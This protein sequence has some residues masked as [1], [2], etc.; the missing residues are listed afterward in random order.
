MGCH[1]FEKGRRRRPLPSDLGRYLALAA[2][3]ATFRSSRRKQVGDRVGLREKRRV[4][5]LQLDHLGRARG[6]YVPLHLNGH[7]HV[8]CTDDVCRWNVSPSRVWHR[9]IEWCARLRPDLAP[10]PFDGAGVTVAVEDSLRLRRIGKGSTAIEHL[11]PG[12]VASATDA[13]E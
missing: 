9:L 6:E 2:E 13:D 7:G 4:T 10:G 5:G 1:A 11:D 3:L 12:R 8:F